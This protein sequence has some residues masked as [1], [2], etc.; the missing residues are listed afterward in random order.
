LDEVTLTA[1][2][3]IIGTPIGNLGDISLRGLETIKGCGLIA[4]EDTRV[5][6]KLLSHYGIKVPLL[7]F[8]DHNEQNQTKRVVETILGGKAVGLISDAGM[9]LISDPG[10]KLIQACRELGIFITVIP[11]ACAVLAG[12]ILS[13]MPPHPF[14]FCGFAEPKQFGTWIH[15]P[16]TIIFFEAPHRLMKTLLAMQ[17]SFVGREVAVV[18][19]ITKRFEETVRGD[20]EKVIE[21]FEAHE[22]RG[23][24][25]IVLGPPEKQ[26]HSRE[27]IENILRPMLETMSVNEASK[28]AAD[29]LGFSK[30]EVYQIAL[31]L[32]NANAY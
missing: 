14:T 25:V 15:V 23:E 6:Q 26:E 17:K 22:P 5:S 11:G 27:D 20:F 9:P 7:A 12:L 18:R 30:R 21:H 24:I 10:Y 32:K 19:E 16:S 29:M 8:H 3:Y 31:S 1:G 13:G 2:L 28:A 4:C